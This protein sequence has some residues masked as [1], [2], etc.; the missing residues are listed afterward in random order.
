MTEL[1][2][3]LDLYGRVVISKRGRDKGRRFVVIGVFGEDRLLVCD[4]KLR[5]VEKPK[6][7]NMNHLTFTDVSIAEI[8]EKLH[9]GEKLVNAHVRKGITQLRDSLSGQG[10]NE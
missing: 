6:K 9:N 7:K 1:L 5:K 2:G 10:R 3:K 4:G 8:R